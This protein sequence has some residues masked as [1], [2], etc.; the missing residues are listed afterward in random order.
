ML[1]SM[2]VG[3]ARTLLGVAER[4]E[5]GASVVRTHAAL[6]DAAEGQARHRDVE[7]GRV[8]A[9]AARGGAARRTRSTIASSSANT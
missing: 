2:D 7:E 8:D 5:A 9:D 1:G 3:L 6:A 4:L